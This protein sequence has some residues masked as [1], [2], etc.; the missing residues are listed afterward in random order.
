MDRHRD[1]ADLSLTLEAELV[2]VAASAIQS[3]RLLKHRRL[4]LALVI[5]GELQHVERWQSLYHEPLVHIPAAFVPDLNC[6]LVL[7]GGSLFAAFELLRYSTIQ[8]CTLVDHDP[9]VLEL[10]SRHYQHAREVL[11][12]PRFHYV[13]ADALTYL[14]AQDSKF[15]L[16]VNDCVDLLAPT[17]RRAGAAFDLVRSACHPAGVCADLIYRHIWDRDH[18]AKTRDALV[19]Q[20]HVALSLVAVPEYPGVLHTLVFWGGPQVNQTA[21]KSVNSEHLLWIE[22]SKK[23]PALEFFDPDRLAFHLYLPPYFLTAWDEAHASK[24]TYEGAPET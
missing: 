2:E 8:R 10:V 15:D 5:N 6:A 16:V 19:D 17:T 3:V 11:V 7:G 9:A 24:L 18:A 23:R 22:N 14:E 4:G 20:R 13:E 12:D 1:A 21:T